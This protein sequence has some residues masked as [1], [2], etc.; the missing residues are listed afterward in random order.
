[1]DISATVDQKQRMLACH[2]SQQAWLRAQQDIREIN[3]PMYAMARRAGELAGFHYA[4]GFRQH[5][6]QGYP[7]TNLLKTLLGD[8]VHG[9]GS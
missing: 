4:E 6:G 1:V 8:L 3:D 9:V 7:Q 2:E 5:L